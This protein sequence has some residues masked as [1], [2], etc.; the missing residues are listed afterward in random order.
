MVVATGPANSG[1]AVRAPAAPV[2]DGRDDDAAWQSAPVFETFTQIEPADGDAPSFP[3]KARVVYDDRNIYVFVRALDP[4]PDSLVARLSR[5]DLETNSDQIGVVIDAYRDRRTGVMFAVNPA[6][7]LFDAVVFNDNQRDVTWD[8][9]WEVATHVDSLGWTAEFRIP[10]SQLRFH[11]L[12]QQRF[13]FGIW[14]DVGRRTERSV[15]PSTYR[16]A[17]QGL[18]SQLGTLDGIAG[19]RRTGKLELRPFVTTQNVTERRSDGW[20]HPQKATA[21]LDLKYGIRENLTLDATVNPDFGQVEADPA[22]LNLTAFEVRF[23]ERRPFFQEGIGLY[24][25]QPCQGLFYTRRI[26][27]TPQLRSSAGDPTTT[28]ILGAAKFTGR[29]GNGVQVGLLDAVTQREVGQSGTTIEP[30]T[31]YLMGRLVKEMRD[32]QSS[33]G[34]VAT[35]VDRDLDPDTRPYLRQESRLAL[36]EGFHRFADGRYEFSG[37]AGGATVAGSAEAIARTQLSPVHLYQRPDGDVRFDPTRTRMS[38]R[39]LSASFSKLTGAVRYNIYLRDSGP[40]NELNDLGLV[41][42]VNDKS[43]RSSVSLQALRPTKYYRGSFSILETENHWTGGGLPASNSVRLHTSFQFH[44]Y[45][46]AALT[47]LLAN[48]GETYCVSCARGGPALRYSPT[49]GVQLNLVGD[50]RGRLTPRLEWADLTSEAGRSNERSG[51]A[52]L[53]LRAGPRFSMSIGANATERTDQQ[54]WVGNYGALLSDTT[55]YTF[56]RLRQ[57]T[58]SLTARASWTATPTL[59][60]QFYGQPFVST[61]RFSDWRE[62]AAPRAAS[63]ED[64]F[65]PYGSGATPPDFNVKQFNSNMVMRWEYAP[66]STFF[67]VWQQGREQDGLNAGTFDFARDYR[68]LFRAHPQNTLLAKVTYWVNP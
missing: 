6:G 49:Y 44:N 38:G 23:E 7:V 46:G 27:R 29:L 41:P 57:T 12:P 67:L 22:I 18:A 14:R 68:D 28:T 35:A 9:V 1:S 21:G 8:G 2:L 66:G 59:S 60:F 51:A 10:F 19:I 53:D 47:T 61:G 45:W 54:Q 42:L 56:A 58:V 43:V 33:L 63:Y 20:A 64:R 15:W 34:L 55:H 16:N 50:Q 3:T 24:R 17:R 4:H 40:G 25:C 11:E 48:Y 39:T 52:S 32:G 5:R 13:G 37:Y 26:G 62:L 31:N 65:T 30:Q 36:V